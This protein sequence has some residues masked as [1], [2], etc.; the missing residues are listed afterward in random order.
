MC[1]CTTLA[2]LFTQSAHKRRRVTHKTGAV[3]NEGE[4]DL[5]SD[6]EVDRPPIKLTLHLRSCALL[7]IY[8]RMVR[9][10]IV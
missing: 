3:L 10:L 5:V 4:S 9:G 1:Y 6:G 8:F 7:I 2:F